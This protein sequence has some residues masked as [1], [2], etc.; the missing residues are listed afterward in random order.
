M[1]ISIKPCKGIG[2]PKSD[3][4]NKSNYSNVKDF[5]GSSY[6]CIYIYSSI[7]DTKEVYMYIITRHTHTQNTA[8]R[9]THTPRTCVCIIY[10][11][12]SGLSRAG[13]GRFCHRSPRLRRR[14]EHYAMAQRG[15]V[16]A[17]HARKRVKQRAHKILYYIY[18]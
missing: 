14:A 8:P 13:V 5:D 16:A 11:G 10:P 3:N 18:T 6:V 1:L 12:I 2:P 4:H 7:H 15:R 17:W 9:T